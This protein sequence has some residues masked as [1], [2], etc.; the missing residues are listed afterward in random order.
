[1]LSKRIYK[2]FPLI[3]FL[4]KIGG[5]DLSF[6]AKSL[7]FQNDAFK[8]TRTYRLRR[9]N[10]GL[11]SLIQLL[12]TMILVIRYLD[13]THIEQFNLAWVFWIGHSSVFTMLSLNYW[14]TTEVC[15][16]DNGI[17]EFMRFMQRKLRLLLT[18]FNSIICLIYGR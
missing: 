12:Q 14:M 6:D 11:F 10:Y 5:C 1:M 7:R 4:H 3:N 16:C 17:L 2:L 13:L 8:S 15:Q 18:N 9:A